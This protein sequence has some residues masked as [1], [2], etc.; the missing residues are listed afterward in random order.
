MDRWN[1]LC[2]DFQH[3]RIGGDSHDNNHHY[4][5]PHDDDHH[6]RD[7]FGDNDNYGESDTGYM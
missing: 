5:T 7:T 4:G 3:R 1:Y 6:Y 2:G